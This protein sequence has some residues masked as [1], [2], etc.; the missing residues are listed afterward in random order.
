M[1]DVDLPRLLSD[2]AG[3]GMPELSRARRNDP[4]E[5]GTLFVGPARWTWRSFFA[6]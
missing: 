6:I 3:V 2:C 1:E 5:I 4:P